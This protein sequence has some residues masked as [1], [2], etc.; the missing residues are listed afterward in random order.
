M[1]SAFR[2]YLTI[3]RAIYLEIFTHFPYHEMQMTRLLLKCVPS[4]TTCIFRKKTF[5][6]DR[7]PNASEWPALRAAAA[8][9]FPER[10][11]LPNLFLFCIAEMEDFL[12]KY[13]THAPYKELSKTC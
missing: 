3:F 11:L 5:W 2:S 10:T 7:V 6:H 9:L 12:P 13:S 1:R 8:H 4:K